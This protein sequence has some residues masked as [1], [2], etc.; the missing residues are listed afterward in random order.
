MNPKCCPFYDIN[1]IFLFEVLWTHI[2]TATYYYFLYC[3]SHLRRV[4]QKN[5]TKRTFIGVCTAYIFLFLTL[6]RIFIT[7]LEI[8]F[9]I[10][11]YFLVCI[12]PYCTSSLVNFG[13]EIWG[14]CFYSRSLCSNTTK[15]ITA[16]TS[17][18]EGKFRS[19]PW[20]CIYESSFPPFF[21]PVHSPLD[22]QFNFYFALIFKQSMQ[23]QHKRY[24]ISN[25]RG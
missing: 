25:S 8:L 21:F 13:L 4:P 11:H 12:F 17:T 9:C 10:N 18:A 5:M 7:H 15:K 14:C 6:L 20:W 23:Q 16:V 22:L 2:S 3:I 24:N 19:M 1:P